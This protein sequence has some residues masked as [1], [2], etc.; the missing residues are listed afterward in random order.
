MAQKV[1]LTPALKAEYEQLFALAKI[2]PENAFEVDAAVTRIT[3][4]ENRARYEAAQAAT[5]VPWF[6]VGII[7]GL[8][9]GWRFDRHLHNGDPL[10]ARTV[11]V[12]KGRPKTGNPP[13]KWEDSAADALALRGLS[14][15][16]DWSL[17]GIAYA[18]EGYNGFGYRL[19]H[20]H[21][22]S[23]YL[24]SFTTIY[25]SGKYVADGQWSDTAKSRQCGAMATL[26]R[27][28]EKGVVPIA[29]AA[30][31]DAPPDEAPADAPLDPDAAALLTPPAP[32]PYPGRVLR[33]DRHGDD[34][35]TLQLRLVALGI[36][37]PGSADGDFGEK[38]EWAVRQFQARAVDEAGSPL[39]IDGVVGPRTWR[40]LFGQP[41]AAPT[42]ADPPA[43]GLAAELVRIAGTQVGVRE[44][45][46]G[47]N[48][49]PEVDAYMARVD[50]SLLGGAWCVAFI[51]WCHDEAARG[52][53]RANPMA[54]TA[55]V[56]RHWEMAQTAAGATIVTPQQARQDPTL[57]VPGMIFHI[58][59]GG[60]TG[61]AG[62][63]VQV[64]G[65]TLVTIEGNSN[66]T[67]SREGIGVFMRSARRISQIDLG[68]VGYG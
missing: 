30:A 36:A 50:P 31:E 1:P 4:P 22:K 8:E 48:R 29:A 60:R 27:L 28:V 45:P 15:A 12:P 33:Q 38:T 59:T 68:F 41:T 16:T 56:W 2:R 23:P 13:F 51:Y 20:P 63:V 11:Q 58:D 6:I 17:A 39:E 52:L 5:G 64:L 67:G 24:W 9:G 32:P 61:H 21:V 53:G 26:K 10:S 14:A 57:V 43:A 37:A 65:Q 66:D 54:R 62:I 19:F 44:V 25:A 34:V 55:S 35:K 49:G 3:R 18:L 7:H 47:S 46:P 40:A 42:P